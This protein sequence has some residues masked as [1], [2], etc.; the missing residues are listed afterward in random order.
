MPVLRRLDGS[1]V[2]PRVET[3]PK[4]LFEK[5]RKG[6]DLW[7]AALLAG[8]YWKS[9]RIICAFWFEIDSDWMPSCCCV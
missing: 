3:R 8:A 2:M 5:T 1:G 6:R 9:F 7:T 4:S